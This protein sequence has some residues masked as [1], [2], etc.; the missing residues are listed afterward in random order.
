MKILSKYLT[1]TV[2]ILFSYL[3][4]SCSDT[5]QIKT[6]DPVEIK[7]SISIWIKNSRIKT[8]SLIQKKN[9][10]SKAY[11]NLNLKP[12]DKYKTKNL[13]IVAYR[14][15]ELKDTL[16]FQK[17]NKETQELAYQLKDSFT[18]ADTHWS[19]ADYYNHRE[20][21]EKSYFHYKEAY[22]FFEKIDKEYQ[23][24]RML[25]AMAFIKGRYRDYSGSE[26]L[27]IKAIEKFKKLN[28]YKWLYSSYNQLAILQND[29]QEYDKSILYH[30]KALVFF[31]KIKSK[32]KKY[33]SSYNNMGSSYF[34]KGNYSK[35]LKYY[36]IDLKKDNNM[37][38]YA[39]I[40]N[41][42]AYCKI[43]LN[44]TINVKR[45]LFEALRIRDSIGNQASV[46]V[47]KI[48]IS[49]YF[50]YIKDTTNALKYVKE[51]NFIAQKIKNGSNYLNSLK[52][53]AVLDIK[54]SKKYLE[55]YI[56]FSDS[57]ST[58]ERKVQNKFTRIEFETDEHIEESKRL[59]EQTIIISITS[60]G[61]ILILSLAYFLRTQKSKNE[62]LVLEA[63][64][65]KANEQVY[66]LTLEQQGII[67]EERVQERNRISEELHDGVLGRL[68]GT[69]VGLGFLDFEATE[70]TQKQHESFLEELQEIEKEIRDVSHKLSNN[71]S[72]DQ[73]N[74]S[75][76]IKQ[77]LK[78]NSATG[79]FKHQVSFD[80][81]IAWKNISQLIKINVYRVVQE[82]LQNIVK[83][84][85]AKNVILDF[86]IE[87]TKLL[88]RIKDDGDGFDIKKAK[89]GIGIK[90]MKSRI[91]KLKGTLEIQSK[92]EQGTT[93]L[94]QIP[95]EN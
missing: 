25:F 33:L 24:A 35:A 75:T 30:K 57:L 20:I 58:A 86:S 5:K 78:T 26:V 94:I 36:N 6:H 46:M 7:D 90:N 16:L 1:I 8:N 70:E 69:R 89:K 40:L 45:D 4:L 3:L 87:K 28:N 43:F 19:L 84:A 56:Q 83:S 18:I 9:N 64:Q 42:R 74:F 55:R 32:N 91:Q 65:Q 41:N 49:D 34:K 2:Y 88:V 80:E 52:K 54:N 21:Y 61:L 47:S 11:N 92:M 13:S 93:I 82:S 50:K 79:N 72:A 81:Q 95:L 71:F 59:S 76:L 27:T 17:I 12:N 29:I 85:H 67:E 60:V 48:N 44:D 53:L 63:E 51:A 22:I 73:I 23:T 14:Y 62:K 37:I 15:Y 38:D 39:R 31:N 68:F 66:L 10:L 77:L